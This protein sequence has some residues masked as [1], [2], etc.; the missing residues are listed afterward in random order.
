MIKTPLKSQE[1]EEIY[2]LYLDKLYKLPRQ[3]M[4]EHNLN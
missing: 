2:P 3:P 4:N 1:E